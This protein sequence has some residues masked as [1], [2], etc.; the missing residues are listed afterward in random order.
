MF[1]L[2]ECVGR[3]GSDACL[4]RS[5]LWCCAPRGAGRWWCFRVSFRHI[6]WKPE[7]TVETI[8]VMLPGFLSMLFGLFFFLGLL[9][10]RHS[11]CAQDFHVEIGD[12][13]ELD[14]PKRSISGLG[15]EAYGN[16]DHVE[17]FSLTHKKWLLGNH[18]ARTW[19]AIIFSKSFPSF[20]HTFYV[21]LS[22]WRLQGCITGTGKLVE[23]GEK[24]SSLIPVYSIVLVGGAVHQQRDMATWL[25]LLLVVLKSR[26]WW[27][28]NSPLG[29]FWR[30]VVGEF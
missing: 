25:L 14:L 29:P 8:L 4:L 9:I 28:E 6:M 10:R 5:H 23:E 24:T 11:C 17:Y 15:Y 20:S 2:S 18:S 16:R 1:A 26:S 12:D 21:P 3:R 30:S 7:V 22:P 27:G 13:P 19:F